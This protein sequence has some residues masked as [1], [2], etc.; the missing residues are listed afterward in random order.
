MQDSISIVKS[1][2]IDALSWSTPAY[3]APAQLL[4]AADTSGV[5]RAISIETDE[6]VWQRHCDSRITSSPRV[7][8]N[9]RHQAVVLLGA[10]SGDFYC[11]CILTGETLW[12][13]KLGS[14][15]RATAAV[16][17]DFD[18]GIQRAFVGVYGPK[19]LCVDVL[20]GQVLWD[21][22]LPKHEY[23]GGTKR[24]IVS[25]P[26]IADVDMDGELEVVTGMRSRRVFCLAAKTGQIKW[27]RELKYDPDSS[28]SYFVVN[29]QPRIYVGG[30]EHTAGQ[31]DN[32]LVCLRGG[33]GKV[34]WKAGGHGG[35]DSCPVIADLNGDG[36]PE[37]VI[38]SLADASCYAFS[39]D[40]G[41]RLWRRRLGPT[42]SCE[43]DANNICVVPDAEYL[44]EDAV[45]RSYTTPLVLHNEQG[46]SLVGIGSN[47]GSVLYLDGASGKIQ[48]IFQFEGMVRG[49]LIGFSSPSAD[50]LVAAVCGEQIV[51]FKVSGYASDW[52]SFKGTSCHGG[53]LMPLE[54][55][56][57]ESVQPKQRLM[58][59]KLLWHWWILDAFRFATFKI[60][61]VFLRPFGIKIFPYYY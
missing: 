21:R 1:Y 41:H 36:N 2:A 38:T 10:E 4:I 27:F 28:P 47:N 16:S 12:Q 3:Y 60:E 25:S 5:I 37:V 32:G 31:G 55:E 40:N 7:E 11:I 14:C 26:L 20:S 52:P 48:E 15:I 49:S 18:D 51:I 19:M 50:Q 22:Y 58:W 45:C 13:S 59:L 23:F 56:N 46:H 54:L 44:T 57:R 42:D 8:K 34:I 43:H 6:I 39:A 53:S 29:G 33:D 61:R 17:S 30:G 24:G 9:A 35:M